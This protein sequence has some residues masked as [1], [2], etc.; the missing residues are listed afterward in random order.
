MYQS[1]KNEG[2][3]ASP[4]GEMR[5]AYMTHSTI[6]VSAGWGSLRGTAQYRLSLHPS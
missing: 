3:T 4:K 6:Q 1:L 2:G 5:P